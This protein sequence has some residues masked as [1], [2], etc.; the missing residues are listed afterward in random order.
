M[1]EAFRNI[2]VSLIFAAPVEKFLKT[3]MVSSAVPK[4]GKSCVASNLAITFAQAKE[5][6]L[7]IDGDMRQG[8]LVKNFEVKNKY[9]LSDMLDGKCGLDEALL[10][11]SI[12]NLSLLCAGEYVPNPTDLLAK[13][14]FNELLEK[15]KGKFQRIVVD[16]PSILKYNDALFWGDKCDGM[17]FVVGAGSTPLNAITAATKKIEGKMNV[18]GGVLNSAAVEKDFYYYY[19]YF[20]SYLE[21]ELEKAKET[22]EKI[23]KPSQ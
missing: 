10:S 21:K 19:H 18:V 12:P 13:E 9:G 16:V 2:K 17:V 14:K 15:V 1:A 22:A 6:T 5:E 20:E 23:K 3:V 8:D 11:T 4:E 7:L